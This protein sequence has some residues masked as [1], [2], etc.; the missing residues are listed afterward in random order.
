MKAHPLFPRLG[1][2]VGR[3]G[4]KIVKA[5]GVGRK[6]GKIVKARGD[7]GRKD[8]KIVKARGGGEI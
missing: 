3:K 2:L 4:G 5:R 8:G 7:V 6:G 1:N